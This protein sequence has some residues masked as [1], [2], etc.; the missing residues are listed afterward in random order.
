MIRKGAFF[1]RKLFKWIS[2]IFLKKALSCISTL[3]GQSAAFL[4]ATWPKKRNL[5][6]FSKSCAGNLTFFEPLDVEIKCA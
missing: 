4:A 2:F 3:Q 1:C 6:I 5:L